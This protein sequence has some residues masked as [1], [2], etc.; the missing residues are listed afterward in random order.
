M[1]ALTI[2]AATAVGSLWLIGIMIDSTIR[3]QARAQLMETRQNGEK[4]EELRFWLEGLSDKLSLIE[5]NTEI[6]SSEIVDRSHA[7][8]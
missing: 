8:A 6:V 1:D 3:N 5:T 7:G 4:L 2:I